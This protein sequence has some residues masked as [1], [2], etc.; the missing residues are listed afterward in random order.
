MKEFLQYNIDKIEILECVINL[1]IGGFLHF[2]DKGHTTS[3]TTQTSHLKK[4]M[5]IA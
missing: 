2:D 3:Q 4:T 1:K 5:K